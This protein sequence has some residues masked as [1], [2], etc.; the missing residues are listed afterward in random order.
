MFEWCGAAGSDCGIVNVNQSTSGAEIGAGFGG[1]LIASSRIRKILHCELTILALPMWQAT[2]PLGEVENQVVTLGSSTALG[3]V[4]LST[5]A[6]SSAWYVVSQP[7]S[8]NPVCM[9]SSLLVMLFLRVNPGPRHQIRISA[10]LFWEDV[11]KLSSACHSL[12]YCIASM[13]SSEGCEME[14][15]PLYHSVSHLNSKCSALHHSKLSL[16]EGSCLAHCSS[17][18]LVI[19]ST[20]SFCFFPRS[21]R[22]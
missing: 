1:A 5:S 4:A 12:E 20:L 13:K 11:I 19:H 16:P 17:T 9:H 2:K 14:T 18:D 15:V 3:R 8:S 21:S 7:C 10:G 22:E 6:D